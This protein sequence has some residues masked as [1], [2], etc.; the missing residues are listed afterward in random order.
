MLTIVEP[1]PDGLHPLDPG[2]LSISKGLAVPAARAGARLLLLHCGALADDHGPCDRAILDVR[3]ERPFTGD[4]AG[5]AS[6]GSRSSI[7]LWRATSA[8][9]CGALDRYDF[10]DVVLWPRAHLGMDFSVACIAEAVRRCRE[11]GGIWLSTRKDKGG[12]R[13]QK[14]LQA[15]AGGELVRIDRA[16]G[17]TLVRVSRAPLIDESKIHEALTQRY[18]IS[19]PDLGELRLCSAP[20]VF[21]RRGLDEGTRALLQHVATR[22]SEFPSSAR[23]LDV[24]A[25]VGPL[26]LVA[27]RRL[28]D[29]RVLAIDSNLRAVDLLAHNAAQ[30]DLST[31]V[32]ARALD[33]GDRIALARDINVWFD[34][35]ARGDIGGAG[36]RA[37][38]L[39]LSNPPTHAPPEVLASMLAGSIERLAPGGRIFA[40]VNRAGRALTAMHDS[41]LHVTA[42]SI[43]GFVVLEG[44][45]A[46]QGG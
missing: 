44:R 16:Q 36:S 9:L 42:H 7:R 40:V 38:D 15:F 12:E 8:E 31:R 13:L 11:G 35:L 28:S 2:M 41:G 3:E 34:E 32:Q 43:G 6:L 45:R 27:A 39:V 4:A 26:S 37:F 25:G 33:A 10:D 21:S 22:W 24:G 17:T 30:A 5:S 1:G 20:G 14:T 29:A 23:I 46:N 18:E 19:D